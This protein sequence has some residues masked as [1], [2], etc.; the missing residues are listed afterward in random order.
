MIDDSDQ[1]MIGADSNSCNDFTIVTFFMKD[2]TNGVYI[3][4]WKQFGQID[5]KL[6]M[7]AG[8]ETTTCL[9]GVARNCSVMAFVHAPVKGKRDKSF[10]KHDPSSA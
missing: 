6:G 5:N 10:A 1:G 2:D 9:L 3:I 8:K 4:G 7:K